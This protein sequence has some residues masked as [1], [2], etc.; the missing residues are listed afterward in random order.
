MKLSRRQEENLA[1]TLLDLGK[2]CVA[3]LILGPL[4]AGFRVKL[5]IVGVLC[6]LGLFIAG[7]IFD[8]G[9]K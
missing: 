4:T 9:D 8:K 2:I 7:L 3:T 1:K 6:S 5:F